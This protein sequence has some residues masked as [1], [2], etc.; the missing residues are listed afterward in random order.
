MLVLDVRISVDPANTSAF[1][2]L[3]RQ[4]WEA[5]HRR[6]PGCRRYEYVRL[7]TPGEYRAFMVF[8]DHDAFLVH[9]ASSHHRELTAA[10]RP[11]MRH[12]AIEFG[13]P[14]AGAFGQADGGSEGTGEVVLAV[15]PEARQHYAA[16]YPAPDFSGWE[17]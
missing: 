7:A 8:D 4:L 13:Q 16:R 12:T 17:P 6:E 5:T 1:E 3:A 11:F 10:M 9:Q 15:D 14:V 2:E